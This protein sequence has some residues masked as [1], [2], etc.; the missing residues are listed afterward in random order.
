[1]E[2]ARRVEATVRMALPA[3]EEPA[4]VQNAI[5]APAGGPTAG[6]G[7]WLMAA[8]GG[9]AALA[10]AGVIVIKI[11]NKD[12]STTELKVPD[13]AKIEVQ[14]DGKTVASVGTEQ[15]PEPRVVAQVEPKKE[16]ATKERPFDPLDPEWV[17]YVRSLTLP[18]SQFAAVLHKL[19]ERNP[20]FD[21]VAI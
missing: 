8:L 11:T 3:P 19:A 17:K 10:V 20:G 13:G 18:R 6:R 5:A 9:L 2:K 4:P 16:P 12:G 15:G 1:R 14:Q 7:G 21:G